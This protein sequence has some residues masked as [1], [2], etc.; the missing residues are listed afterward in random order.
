V[1]WATVVHVH[2]G[3]DVTP[4]QQFVEL[5]PG[6][7]DSRR[8]RWR[9]KSNQTQIL[10]EKFDPFVKQSKKSKLGWRTPTQ[11][12][13]TLHRSAILNRKNSG[14]GMQAELRALRETMTGKSSRQILKPK[15]STDTPQWVTALRSI[16]KIDTTQSWKIFQRSKRVLREHG[17][18]IPERYR[19]V[20][21]EAVETCGGVPGSGAS[22]HH[23]I[24]AVV[25]KFFSD[26]ERPS[27]LPGKFR[28]TN[29]DLTKS[30]D[31]EEQ[32]LVRAPHA[33][34]AFADTQFEAHRMRVSAA[35]K[36]L[37]EPLNAVMNA[38]KAGDAERLLALARQGADVLKGTSG[39][40]FTPLH[41]AAFEGHND[42]IQVRRKERLMCEPC[43]HYVHL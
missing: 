4:A 39:A 17:A 26:M 16:L 33:K 10:R 20:L 3:N 25:D 27:D 29:I 36:H 42:V 8:V 23:S 1:G 6:A 32:I 11:R 35:L 30:K 21:I 7:M 24:E 15:L 28:W 31:L 5:A 13:D 43:R 18:Q 12:A 22:V 14:H 19:H 38:S 34:A 37:P 40:G 2:E 9:H 41:I